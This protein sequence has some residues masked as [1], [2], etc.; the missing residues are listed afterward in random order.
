MNI[1]TKISTTLPNGTKVDYSVILTFKNPTT[2]KDYVIYTDNTYDQNKHLRFFAAK[3]DAS[4]PNPFL[5]EPTTKEEWNEIV[6]II[7]EVI[8]V[9]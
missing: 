6:R 3:Y 4:L 2:N 5:G 8:P 9:K 7:D 1:P